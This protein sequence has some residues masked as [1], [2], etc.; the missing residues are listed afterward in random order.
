MTRSTLL[1]RATAVTATALVGAFMFALPA[2]AA[3]VTGSYAGPG[4][5]YSNITIDETASSGSRDAG[6]FTFQIEGGDTVTA[7]CIQYSVT[8]NKEGEF[9]AVGRDGTPVDA[10]AIGRAAWIGVNHASVGT[11]L[12]DANMEAVAAAMAAWTFT[13]SKT[14]TEANML[15]PDARARAEALRT[16]ALAATPLPAGPT[17]FELKVTADR[18]A[19]GS[20]VVADVLLTTDKGE[21]LAGEEVEVTFSDGTSTKVTT[22]SDGRATATAEDV[23]AA[24]TVAAAWSGVLPAGSVLDSQDGGQLVVTLRA[25]NVSRDAEAEFGEAPVPVV[26][27][28]PEPEPVPDPEPVGDDPE[29]VDEPKDEPAPVDEPKDEPKTT[30]RTELPYTGPG[31]LIP[32]ILAGGGGAAFAGHRMRRKALDELGY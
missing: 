8:L 13:D 9:V 11:P 23:E 18:S 4:A 29:P 30:E 2:A 20:D 14:W 31:L 17:S 16:A 24:G 32:L 7:L 3:P 6:F 28:E 25:A 1:H 22:D 19:D 10:T 26:D 21:A 5:G 15:Y 27:V 12:S